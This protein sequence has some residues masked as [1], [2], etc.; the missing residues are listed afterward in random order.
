MISDQHMCRSMI[1]D[2]CLY[3]SMISDQRLYRPR[4][5]YQ[6]LCRS[7]ISDI[8]FFTS[9]ISDICLY[10]SMI[11]SPPWSRTLKLVLFFT[12]SP[13]SR[14]CPWRSTRSRPY[15]LHRSDSRLFK[16]LMSKFYISSLILKFLVWFFIFLSLVFV[17]SGCTEVYLVKGQCV[18]LTSRRSAGPAGKSSD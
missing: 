4:I 3:K 2:Q 17:R 5:S 11:L 9:I 18:P 14:T 1:C 16:Y 6:S 15:I 10:R 13:C 8:C 12:F 7:M